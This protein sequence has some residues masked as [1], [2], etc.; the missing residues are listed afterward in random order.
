MKKILICLMAITFFGCD[1]E[2]EIIDQLIQEEGYVEVTING[3]TR[4]FD[5]APGLVGASLTSTETS[6]GLIH[7]FAFVA[8]DP[9]SII[10]NS[11]VTHVGMTLTVESPDAIIAGTT[12]NYPTNQLSGFYGYE[13]GEGID[14]DTDETLSASLTITA[15]NTG[16]ETISGT[17]GYVVKEGFTGNTYTIS[18]GSFTNIP[19]SSDL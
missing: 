3:Q 2:E 15:I 7:G 5:Y 12:F 11:E 17:F 1:I 16:D 9:D 14:I 6:I 10:N 8:L 4:V 18:N 13:N 19:F